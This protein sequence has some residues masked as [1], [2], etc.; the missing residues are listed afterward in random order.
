MTPKETAE[1]FRRSFLAAW[2]AGV[3]VIPVPESNA[4]LRQLRVNHDAQDYQTG[5]RISPEHLEMMRQ[6][7]AGEAHRQLTAID[8]WEQVKDGKE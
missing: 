3:E 6:Q 7:N 8:L 2:A 1:E 5:R 4:L